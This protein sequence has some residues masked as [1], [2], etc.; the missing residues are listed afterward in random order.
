[1]AQAARI[2]VHQA[3]RCLDYLRE[4]VEANQGEGRVEA[5]ESLLALND[6]L[7]RFEK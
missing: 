1:M 3:R 4:F 2:S 6:Y 5:G 7:E